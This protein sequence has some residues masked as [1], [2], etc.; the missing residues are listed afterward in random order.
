MPP[1]MSQKLG[2]LGL[3]AKKLTEQIAKEGKAWLGARIFV[4]IHAQ[5]RQAT[6]HFK[7]GTSTY[8]IKEMGGFVTRD[9]KKEKL[10]NRTGNI[11]FDQVLKVARLVD[12]EGK[13]LSKTFEGT[14]KQVIGTC[15]TVGCTIDGLSPK[16]ITAKVNSGE[17]TCSK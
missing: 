3:Q 6:I 10:P 8:I 9:R 2:P 7:P 14:V 11:T 5:N 17:Y 16:D 13:T 12:E 4:E 15:L 1:S